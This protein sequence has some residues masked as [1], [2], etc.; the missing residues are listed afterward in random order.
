MVELVEQARLLFAKVEN[1]VT[2][3]SPETGSRGDV[4]GS[5]EELP[6]TPIEKGPHTGLK[7]ASP[8]RSRGALTLR[9]SVGFLKV[10]ELESYVGGLLFMFI[11]L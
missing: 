5:G 3:F 10:V 8:A 4:Y 11:L 2:K 6:E 7:K 9:P 1:G